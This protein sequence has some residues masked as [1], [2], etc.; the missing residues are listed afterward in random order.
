M[1][2]VSLAE[3]LWPRGSGPNS[4]QAYLLLDGA[5]DKHIVPMLRSSG[6]PYECLYEGS[7]SPS[8]MAAAPYIVQI[9]PESRF[10]N[11]LVPRGWHKAWG[12]Y[13]VAQPNVTLQALRRHFRTLLRVRDQQGR[14]LVFRFYDPRVLRIYLPTCTALE[15][16][17]FFGPVQTMAW[18]S[19][20]GDTLVQ[21]NLSAV[22]P[23]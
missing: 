2:A 18:E 9:A 23:D 19:E 15:R 22:Q 10:F 8:L 6:L 5:R 13:V 14:I 7:L 16:K 20:T 11:Q 21:A 12:I 4:P 17:M 3:Q 1:D